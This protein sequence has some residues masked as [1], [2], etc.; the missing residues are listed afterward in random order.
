MGKY[1]TLRLIFSGI[2]IKQTKI[3]YVPHIYLASSL[4]FQPGLLIYMHFISLDTVCQ[5]IG[6]GKLDIGIGISVSVIS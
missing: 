5:Y 3:V 1:A 6:I 2:G 4:H